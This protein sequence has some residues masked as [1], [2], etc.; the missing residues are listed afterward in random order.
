[1]NYR[2]FLEQG[3]SLTRMHKRNLQ[4]VLKCQKGL[5]PKLR[6]QTEEEQST[7]F[8]GWELCFKLPGPLFF[9]DAPARDLPDLCFH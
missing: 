4:D 9:Q 7:F 6:I 5:F 1:M 3:I 8:S 2:W